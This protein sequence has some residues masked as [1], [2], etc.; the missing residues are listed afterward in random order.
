MT[1]FKSARLKL[2]FLYL[3][4]IMI[5]SVSF[6][7]GIYGIMSREMERFA[8]SQ[9]F[10][11]EGRM[12]FPDQSRKAN[13]LPDPDL[14]W[15]LKSRLVVYLGFINLII[16]VSAGLLGYL[17]A[18]WTLKP[19]ARM[20]EDQARFIS[21][22]S[23]ELKTP[24]TALKSSFEVFLRE[25]KPNIAEAREL[26]KDS[27][28]DVDNLT[29][30]ASSL[31]TLSRFSEPASNVS[32]EL[33]DLAAVIR[34]VVVAIKPL[35]QKRQINLN[36]DLTQAYILG[37]TQKLT[38]LFTILLDNAIKYNKESGKVTVKATKTDGY[39]LIELE[40]SGIGISAEDLPHI[41]DRF[42]RADPSRTKNYVDG[43]GLGLAIAKKIVEAHKGDITVKSQVGVGTAFQV[44]F[45]A[46]DFKSS[47]EDHG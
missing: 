17:L 30:L 5:I 4:I 36:I 15:E 19:I 3:L 39:V 46:I 28:K 25:P 11:I 16:L 2:T 9:R 37:D 8:R 42:Y 12:F 32:R 27:V 23:H 22:A 35:A 43:H 31:L 26:I 18:G 1:L 29:K 38:E 24:L 41:F 6:S 10:R 33:V 45:K 20:L 7:V 13:P 47:K 40:D 14:L 34:D 21:D 44:K